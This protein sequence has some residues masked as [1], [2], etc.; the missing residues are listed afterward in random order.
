MVLAYALFVCK[1]TL[2]GQANQ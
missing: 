2:S 1:C